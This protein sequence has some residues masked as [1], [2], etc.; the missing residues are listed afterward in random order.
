MEVIVNN[1][2]KKKGSINVGTW[3]MWEHGDHGDLLGSP[4]RENLL[5]SCKGGSLQTVLQLLA[6]SESPQLRRALLASDR[7]CLLHAG[8]SLSQELLPGLAESLS[9]LHR[10]QSFLPTSSSSPVYPG[11]FF[12]PYLHLS[13]CFKTH[14]T[15]LLAGVGK[16]GG[17]MYFGDWIHWDLG[18]RHSGAKWQ[19]NC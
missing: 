3:M 14:L 9:G 4:S 10:S 13:V 1:F 17:E 6:T 5:C 12:P 7:P 16:A 18:H 11:C 8:C 15:L 19:S 2:K